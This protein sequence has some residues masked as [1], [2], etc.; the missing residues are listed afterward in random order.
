MNIS[1]LNELIGSPQW[2]C[3]RSELRN[4]KAT[5]VPYDPKNG[6]RASTADAKTWGT[7]E[8]AE[9]ALGDPSNGYKGVGFVFTENDPYTGID[10]DKCRDPETG[11]F[12]PW[13]R[14]LIQEIGTY[15]EIS[16][17]GR[18]VHMF[19]RA[20]LPGAGHRAG[21]IEIYSSGRYFT[22]TGES[23]PDTPDLIAERQELIDRLYSEGR[24]SLKNQPRTTKKPLAPTAMLTFIPAPGTGYSGSP[25]SNREDKLEDLA[26][27][28]CDGYKSPSEADLAFC[29]MLADDTN[30][31]LAEIDQ[32]FRASARY[33]PKWDEK[34]GAKTYGETTL[35]MAIQS[36]AGQRTPA[37]LGRR[38]FPMNAKA[39]HGLIGDVIRTFEPHTE[40]DPAALLVQFLV[41]FG[42]VIGRSA[43]FK[44]EG[45]THFLN[46]FAV[47]AGAS[48]KARK[49]TSLGRIKQL[50]SGQDGWGTTSGLS[51]GEGLI[52]AVADRDTGLDGAGTQDKRLMV[53]EPEFASPLKNIDRDGNILSA[54]MRQAWDGGDLSV[55]TRHSPLKA[56]K[57]HI[58]ILGHITVDELRRCLTMSE[59]A[60]GFANRFLWVSAQRSKLLPEGG[61]LADSDLGRL[62]VAVQ[63]AIRF[64]TFVEEMRMDE[65]ARSLWY[66]FYADVSQ[67]SPG[68][69]GTLTAR[70]EPQVRRMACLYALLDHS[71]LVRQEHLEAAI[72]VWDYCELSVK[73]IF[74]DASGDLIAD[75][76]ARALQT[77]PN[78]L[79]ATE[80]SGLFGNNKK[81]VDTNAALT[82][83][84]DCGV[85][86]QEE[87]RGGASCDG[88]ET[89]GEC[90]G[91]NLGAGSGMTASPYSLLFN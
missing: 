78:G 76:I 63:D 43:H 4:G 44:V 29:R 86:T 84:R 30:G 91:A 70:A 38:V 20:K 79:T 17:S 31:D 60:N 11:E 67:G 12:E 41:M 27:G 81:A 74:G 2:L 52:A 75:T 37:E 62:K 24:T 77:Q 3:W 56:T 73:H 54:T 6:D 1:A 48:S 35:Q 9:E 34:R 32:R 80:I 22:V 49:G 71:S 57:S 28:Q 83:L 50:F 45:D 68:L 55:M 5:K 65:A 82:R 87:R 39:H 18:G 85:I 47:I 23:V 21:Q 66:R 58:S 16:P 61:H 40:A 69:V 89:L 90:R 33:R 53:I 13:A 64:A 7:Y 36:W 25:W 15:T 88:L 14:E 19:V 46:L 59:Q 72:S 42:N 26:N 8:Q 10:L 51:S